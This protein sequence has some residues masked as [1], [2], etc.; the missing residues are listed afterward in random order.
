MCSRIHDFRCFNDC[1]T[2]LRPWLNVHLQKTCG[3]RPGIRES[4]ILVITTDANSANLFGGPR[5]VISAVMWS[6]ARSSSS[7]LR[8]FT[9]LN[10][11]HAASFFQM[12]AEA[13]ARF[14]GSSV[15]PS[16][17]VIRLQT[18]LSFSL[19]AS[20][21]QV[22]A[23][24]DFRFFHGTSFRDFAKGFN[25]L[26]L[27]VLA[28]G[29]LWWRTNHQACHQWKKLVANEFKHSAEK[30]QINSKHN[31]TQKKKKTTFLS[32]NFLTM[33]IITREK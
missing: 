10:T 14:M 17:A 8:L 20:L 16:P 31:N 1:Q 15:Q 32:A 4:P 11:P 12:S 28:A 30:M 7:V 19:A 13:N 27:V 9:V 24:D 26:C 18:V 29:N 33:N 3:G 21:L 5:T 25:H 23:K 2:I 22:S 6:S